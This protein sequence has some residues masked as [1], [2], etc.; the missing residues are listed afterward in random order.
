MVL[1]L[2][3]MLTSRWSLSNDT[4]TTA[5]FEEMSSRGAGRLVLVA[6]EVM[7]SL[8]HCGQLKVSDHLL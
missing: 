4:R 3:V 2:W 8:F 1:L 6:Q 7:V 5:A